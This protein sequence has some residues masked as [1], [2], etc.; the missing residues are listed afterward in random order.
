MKIIRTRGNVRNQGD[1]N[2]YF[3]FIIYAVEYKSIVM[4]SIKVFHHIAFCIFCKNTLFFTDYMELFN[5]SCINVAILDFSCMS[6]TSK[7]KI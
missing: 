2:G 6:P 5:P 3:V 7:N 4:K 1:N